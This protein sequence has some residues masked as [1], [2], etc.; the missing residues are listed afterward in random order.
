[1]RQ[2]HVDVGAHAHQVRFEDDRLDPGHLADLAPPDIGDLGGGDAA[3]LALGEK[4]G[5]AAQVRAG[6]AAAA[7]RPSFG[8]RAAGDAVEMAQ[9]R[10]ARPAAWPSNSAT[11]AIA[12]FSM[13][14]LHPGG[15]LDRGAARHLQGGGDHVAVHLRHEGEFDQAAADHP[16][17]QM[18]RATA[19]ARVT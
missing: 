14:L 1:M 8:H 4:Q 3:L 5:D 17:R 7:G 10:L 9:D 6:G 11:V 13:I 12:C 2:L 16:R 18:S 19:L 15:L